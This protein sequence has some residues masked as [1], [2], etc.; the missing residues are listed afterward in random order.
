MCT[1]LQ[2]LMEEHDDLDYDN[3]VDDDY[4][5]SVLFHTSVYQVIVALG[6]A[7]TLQD[8][9][10]WKSHAWTYT[11]AWYSNNNNNNN[12]IFLTVLS[13]LTATTSGGRG[14]TRGPSDWDTISIIISWSLK[15]IMITIISIMWIICWSSSPRSD[16]QRTVRRKWADLL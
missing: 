16:S 1:K 14:V 7:S 10:T 3:F 15:N 8:R 13:A 12:N 5:N 2:W 6:R 11:I 9:T 4:D